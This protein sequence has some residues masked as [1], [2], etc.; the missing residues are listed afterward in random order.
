MKKSISAI[1]AA[2][3]AASALTAGGISASAEENSKNY[4]YGDAALCRC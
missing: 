1:L 2:A 4:I 3:I